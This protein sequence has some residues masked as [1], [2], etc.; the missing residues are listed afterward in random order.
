MS[1]TN[2]IL[3]LFTLLKKLIIISVNFN[4][5]ISNDMSVKMWSLP[6]Y[7]LFLLSPILGSWGHF[8]WHVI[9]I[10][11]NFSFVMYCLHHSGI[12]ELHQGCTRPYYAAPKNWR[13][14]LPRGA[15]N[16]FMSIIYVMALINSSLLRTHNNWKY[17]PGFCTLLVAADT[18]PDVYH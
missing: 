13:W 15:F 6:F 9:S 3:R 2:A 17:R 8:F 1:Q 12:E 16:F 4:L 11:I 14:Q 10:I 7:Y 5:L 18:Q